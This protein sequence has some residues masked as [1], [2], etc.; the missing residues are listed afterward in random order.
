M[1]GVHVGVH[2]LACE[3]TFRLKVKGR[4]EHSTRLKVEQ[5]FLICELRSE[6]VYRL[7]ERERS[8]RTRCKVANRDSR[9]FAHLMGA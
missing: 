1:D 2:E 5:R 9:P 7:E 3:T 8:H 4:G 6:Q